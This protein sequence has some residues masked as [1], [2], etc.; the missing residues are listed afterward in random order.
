MTRL[1]PTVRQVAEAAGVSPATVCNAM[2]GTGRLSEAT[3]IRVLDA[4]ENAGYRPR[5]T[6]RAAAR[7]RTGL[8]GLTLATYGSSP[9]DY[10]EIPFHANLVLGA[11]SAA[12][13]RGFLLV[14]LPASTSSWTWMSSPLD[15][16]I[17][18]EPRASD[19]VLALLHKRRLPLVTIGP[20]PDGPSSRD[21]S[22][23]AVVD[24]D[25]GAAVDLVLDHLRDQ[26]A[27]RPAVLL[28][29]HDDAYPENVRAAV[30]AWSL[31]NEI[32]VAVRTFALGKSHR[33][34]EC[35][36]AAALLQARPRADAIVGIY[37]PSG[38][39]I[40]EVAAALNLSVPRQVKVACFS[41]GPEYAVSSPPLTT[42]EWGARTIGE[43]AVDLLLAVMDNRRGVSRHRLVAPTLV[44]RRST[45]A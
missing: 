16:V 40:L 43:Q 7:G 6:A 3:R 18:C 24:S 4:I 39:H 41:E 25:S 19:P 37:E 26:G 1:H 34:A 38:A 28:P 32:P 31:R 14:V 22:M 5:V 13:R 42:V 36:A 23:D 29:E 15:G 21:R 2:N 27:R 17:H 35:A 33:Q 8:L 10:T 44:V 45:G 30:E 12:Q 9:V 11:I 20:I